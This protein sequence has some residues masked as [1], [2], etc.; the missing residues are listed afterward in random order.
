MADAA[1]GS[2]AVPLSGGPPKS[3]MSDM[4]VSPIDHASGQ[5]YVQALRKGG[6]QVLDFPD[7]WI[8]PDLDLTIWKP[9]HGGDK[10]GSSSYEA[11]IAHDA[12]FGSDKFPTQ[13]GVEYTTR[14]GVTAD[15]E[16]AVIANAKKAVEAGMGKASGDLHVVGKSLDKAMTIAGVAGDPALMARAKAVREHQTAVE[17]GITT[18]G[19]SPAQK[20]RDEARFLAQTRAAF[21]EAMHASG[22]K[23]ADAATVL[24]GQLAEAQAR[25]DKPTAD[26]LRD[27]L[28]RYKIS[29][30]ITLQSLASRD[31]GTVAAVLA[32]RNEVPPSNHGYGWLTDELARDRQALERQTQAAATVIKLPGV[33]E[34]CRSAATQVAGRLAALPTK[35]PEAAYLTKLKVALERGAS[36][37]GLAVSEV[38]LLSGYEL[39]E[40]LRDLGSR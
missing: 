40:V 16:G 35:S 26:K 36:D 27:Q 5:K 38:R 1:L 24:K 25:R 14:D 3:V 37:P 30:Q 7:R 29:N 20:A 18:F 33:G 32:R 39:S 4:D 10:P 6:R 11:A 15:A 31:P 9:G 8:A 12:M 19:A 13:G 21:A 28:A 17:A 2:A 34:R 23:S 22:Q